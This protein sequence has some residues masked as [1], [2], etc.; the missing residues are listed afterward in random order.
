MSKTRNEKQKYFKVCNF[1]NGGFCREGPTCLYDHLSHDCEPHISGK[2]TDSTCILRH[3]KMCKL[4]ASSWCKREAKCESLHRG[5]NHSGTSSRSDSSRRS[6][7]SDSSSRS[8]RSSSASR[9]VAEEKLR[10]IQFLME[11][12]NLAANQL[13]CTLLC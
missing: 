5:I 12:T 8:S 6:S 11:L 1:W 10:T 4:W 3:R 9:R 7:R 2:C 13:F